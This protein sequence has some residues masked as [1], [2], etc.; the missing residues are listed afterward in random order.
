MGWFRQ[1]VP[2]WIR[3]AALLPGKGYRQLSRLI[4]NLVTLSRLD[5]EDP[6]PVRSEFSLTDAL[7]E[8][9]ESFVSLSR[10]KGKIYTQEIAD[11]LTMTGDKAAIQQMVSILLDNALKYSSEGGFL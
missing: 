4:T 3:R 9:S 1:A 6:F 7:W 10:A 2:G 8:I 5:E 11:G